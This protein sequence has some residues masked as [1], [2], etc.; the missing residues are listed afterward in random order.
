MI[1]AESF[2]G[3]GGSAFAV[4]RDVAFVA[5]RSEVVAPLGRSGAGKTPLLRVIVGLDQT[6]DGTVTQMPGPV[7]AV[8]GASASALAVHRRQPV[9][10]ASGSAAVRD[11]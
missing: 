9:P 11:H 3:P 1:R 8:P 2:R 7:G 4:L 10:G 6:F 5:R